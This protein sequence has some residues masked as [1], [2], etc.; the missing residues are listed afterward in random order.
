M[1]EKLLKNMLVCSVLFSAAA[2]AVMLH[3]AATKTIVIAEEA[4]P[5]Q[6]LEGR[7]HGIISSRLPFQAEETIQGLEIP[8]P[9][10]IRA[11][12]IVIENRYIENQIHVV[13]AGKYSDF[14]RTRILLGNEKLIEGGFI[15]EENG[16]TRLQLEMKGLYE[17]QYVFENGMLQLSF[18]EP[19]GMY[20]KIVVLDAAGGGEENGNTGGGI[21]EKKLALEIAELVREKLK[22]TDIRVYCTRTDDTA[23]S[24]ERRVEFANELDADLLISIGAGADPVNEKVFGIQTFYNSSY[25]IPYFGNVQLADL[26]ERSTVTAAGGKANGLFEADPD[27]I[28][29]QGVRMPAAMIEVGYLTNEEETARLSMPQYKEKLAEGIALAIQEA[30]AEMEQNP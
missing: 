17:H 4:V 14:Y 22:D 8:L 5:G 29:L 30:F 18:R 24:G 13:L 25:F 21:I 9:Q 27:K 3:F 10:E 6:M 20:D 15:S 16:K 23:V 26:L 2:M 12:D 28:L 1:Q 19:S 7:M 11:D